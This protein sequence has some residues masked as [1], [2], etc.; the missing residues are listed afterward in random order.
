M[1]RKWISILLVTAL[2]TALLAGCGSSAASDGSVDDTGAAVTEAVTEVGTEAGTE[3]IVKMLSADIEYNALDYVT[4][5]AYDPVEVTLYEENYAVTDADVTDYVNNLI[6][7]YAT[8]P[9]VED[10][11][12]T[13]VEEG[14]VVNVD[15]VGKLDGTAFEGGTAEGTH[16]NTGTNTDAVAGS[17]YIDGFSSGLIGATVGTTIDSEVTFPEEYGNETLNGQTVV[18]TFTVNAIETQITAENMDDAFV[19]ENLSATLG[20][21]FNTETAEGFVSDVKAYLESQAE[22]QEASDKM[23]AVIEAVQAVCTVNSFPEGLLEARV[24]EY[25]E[26]FK[27]QY[28]SDTVTL[29]D[30]LSTQ[31]YGMTVEEFNTQ[32]ETY[33]SDS[34]TTELIFEAIADQEKIEA[35]PEG[36]A[37]YMDN[38]VANG[39]YESVDA[40]YELYGSTPEIGKAYMEKMYRVQ[41]AATQVSDNAT[42]IYGTATE[43]DAVESTTEVQTTETE[44]TEAAQ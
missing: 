2:S 21:Y 7:N 3:T 16:I 40:V 44:A 23:S 6:L 11:S 13:V 32:I 24:Q 42:V 28:T 8:S 30:Y 19:S 14:D 41:L 25:I 43:T 29:E 5:G 1:K 33:M 18:F 34:L 38:V 12:K 31:Y 35:D 10:T 17:G 39:S 9:F 4:L 27:A 37:T 20:S 36:F 26:S 22:S 15:Y